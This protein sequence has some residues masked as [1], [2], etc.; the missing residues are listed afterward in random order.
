M[1]KKWFKRAE[2]KSTAPV[3]IDYEK[4]AASQEKVMNKYFIQ[5]VEVLQGAFAEFKEAF[6]ALPEALIEGALGAG[7]PEMVPAEPTISDIRRAAALK[8]VEA[9]KKKKIDSLLEG[10]GETLMTQAFPIGKPVLEF[11]Y[12]FIPGLEGITEDNPELQQYLMTSVQQFIARNLPRLT[13]MMPPELKRHIFPQQVP[14]HNPGSQRPQVKPTGFGDTGFEQRVR[15]WEE[16][17]KR[18]EVEL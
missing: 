10:A 18:E 2:E 4:I 13:S 1:F 6:E 3:E 5:L 15:Q 9:R 11:L 14:Q 17:K 16:Q 7:S 12:G 8:G